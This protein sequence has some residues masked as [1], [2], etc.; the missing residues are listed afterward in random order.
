MSTRDELRAAYVALSDAEKVRLADQTFA[1]LL[2][3][4]DS[5]ADFVMNVS[6]IYTDAIG[7]SFDFEDEDG[8]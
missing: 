8:F 4:E 6:N 3:D 1:E 7:G 5:G 2:S